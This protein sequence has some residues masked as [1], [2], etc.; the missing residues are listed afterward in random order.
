MEN[1]KEYVY[2]NA[3]RLNDTRILDNDKIKIHP[4]LQV[5]LQVPELLLDGASRPNL[6]LE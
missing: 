5:I 4:L 3:P 1:G 6:K 2:K